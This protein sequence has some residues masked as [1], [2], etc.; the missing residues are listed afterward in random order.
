M[1]PINQNKTV[2]Q[3]TPKA[4]SNSTEQTTRLMKLKIF[5]NRIHMIMNTS[6]NFQNLSM[7]KTEVIILKKLNHI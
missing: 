5:Q 1:P 7:D 6:L 3:T 4:R 2:I